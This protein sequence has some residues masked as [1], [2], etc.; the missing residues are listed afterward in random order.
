MSSVTQ[1][2]VRI[3][4]ESA[5]ECVLTADLPVS[6]SRV[7]RAVASDEVTAWWVRPGVFDTREWSGDVCA[8]GRW[9]C[10]GDARGRAYR[11]EGEFLEIDTPR[12]LTHTWHGV[13]APGAPTTVAYLIE[14]AAGGTRLTLTHAGFAS[15]DACHNH[16]VG[17]ETSLQRLG[18]ILAQESPHTA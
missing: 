6:P 4:T 11:L 9:Q 1:G 7:F 18:E 5:E 12:T 17:W 8:G 3:V 16:C 13:G 2:A 15:P 14:A 10:A